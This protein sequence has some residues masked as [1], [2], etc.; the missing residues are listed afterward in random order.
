MTDPRM[1]TFTRAYALAPYPIDPGHRGV[2]TSVEAAI[3][4]KPSAQALRFAVYDTLRNH[5]AQGATA[6]QL[7]E[8]LR[9]PYANVQPRLSELRRDGQIVDSGKRGHTPSGKPCIVW[10][11]A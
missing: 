7:A 8:H 1:P 5:F 3:A 6:H 4:V 9:E 11:L 2:D 10:R